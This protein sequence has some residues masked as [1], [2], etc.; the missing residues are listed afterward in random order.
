MGAGTN[1]LFVKYFRI[2]RDVLT[3]SKYIQSII[4]RKNEYGKKIENSINWLWWFYV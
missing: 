3:I 1:I 2:F 4:R